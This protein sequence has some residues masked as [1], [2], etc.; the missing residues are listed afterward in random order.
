ML[1]RRSFFS[2][3]GGALTAA[4]VGAGRK[5]EADVAWPVIDWNAP[6]VTS[7]NGYEKPMVQT[8][9]PVPKDILEARAWAWFGPGTPGFDPD[10]EFGRDWESVYNFDT[11]RVRY[12]LA[13]G[14]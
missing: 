7:T 2:W 14:C 1:T 5:R 9:G 13:R 11:G 8:V 10:K 3:I 12:R 6:H 4:A